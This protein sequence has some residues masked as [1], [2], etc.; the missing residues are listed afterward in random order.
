MVID[1]VAVKELSAG[2]AWVRLSGEIGTPV[3]WKYGVR[4]VK[5]HHYQIEPCRGTQ[6][7]STVSKRIYQARFK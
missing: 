4:A 5:I 6:T 2:Q 3:T 7:I 1:G